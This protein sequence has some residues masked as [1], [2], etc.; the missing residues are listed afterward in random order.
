MDGRK[1]PLYDAHIKG[2]GKMVNFNGWQLP[3][4]F[5]G[6]IK[7]HQR[8]RTLAGLFDVSHMG[9]IMVVGIGAE[10]F[11]QRLV[12]ADCAK[13]SDRQVT[14]SFLCHE[15]G[16]VIDDLL[17]YKF[18]SQRFLLVVNAV[19][20]EKDLAWVKAKAPS[21]VAVWDASEGYAQLALQGPRSQEIL[22]PLC[23]AD[24]NALRPFWFVDQTMVAGRTALLSRTGYT[25]EDGF[26]LYLAAIDA[27]PVW[28]AL[29]G[30]GGQHIAPIGLGARDTLR[31]EAR[32]PLYGQELSESINPLE[33]GLGAFVKFN[34]GDFVGREALWRQKKAGL[35]RKLVELEMVGRGIA[36]A[37]YEVYKE[38][39]HIG[40][41]TTGSFAPT[42]QKNVALALVE[43]EHSSAG[44]MVEVSIRNSM[45]Q[46]RINEDIFYES[47]Y[48]RKGKKGE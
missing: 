18:S 16:G 33:A 35:R 34:K 44:G 37:H 6:I 48:R 11:M 41:I 46:A 43:V 25:G 21:D 10:T 30:Q 2:Q 47:V 7:E 45:V 31:F 27:L 29:L 9:E 28:E 24:L 1:T 36:R 19:N 40:F 4:E 3:L 5:E 8:V 42:L 15:Q 32:L 23:T 38:G 14:Y 20:I 13:M 39:R 26:E 17:V 22:A 12:T